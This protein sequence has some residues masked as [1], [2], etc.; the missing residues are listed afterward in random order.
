MRV[1]ELMTSPAATVSPGARVAEAAARMIAERVGSLVVVE[2][3]A[4]GHPVGILTQSDLELHEERVPMAQHGEHAPRLL[5]AWAQDAAQLEAALRRAPAKTVREVMS[6]P[7]VTVAPDAE[8]WDA[9]QTMVARGV[10]HLPV[11][12]DGRLVGMM[13][14][15][16]L[17]KVI[18]RLAREA[19]G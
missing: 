12:E 17:L 6:A 4:P 18:V 15:P 5:G 11:V 13:A 10:R 3:D 1:R 19:G 2:P 7:A 16:D 8:V 14:R 9:L